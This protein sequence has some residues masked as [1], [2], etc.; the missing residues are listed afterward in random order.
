MSRDEFLVKYLNICYYCQKTQHSCSCY[1]NTV[2][3]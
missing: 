2:W 1:N 3:C